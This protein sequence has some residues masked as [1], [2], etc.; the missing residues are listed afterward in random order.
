VHAVEQ[1]GH[2]ASDQRQVAS[3]SGSVDVKL[4]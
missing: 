3:K 4:R 2:I 1:I